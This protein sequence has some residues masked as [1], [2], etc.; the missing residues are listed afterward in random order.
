MRSGREGA[1]LFERVPRSA[2]SILR[3]RHSGSLFSHMSDPQ[4]PAL[5]MT[6]GRRKGALRPQPKQKLKVAPIVFPTIDFRSYPWTDNFHDSRD[7]IAKHQYTFSAVKVFFKAVIKDLFMNDMR[8]YYEI[9]RND[10]NH[11]GKGII[12]T[13]IKE[14]KTRQERGLVLSFSVFWVCT[15]HC[16]E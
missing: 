9:F 13:S 15:P 7:I 11:L 10:S 3:S 12:D 4:W 6:L 14:R 1:R 2:R 8:W 16:A 5:T